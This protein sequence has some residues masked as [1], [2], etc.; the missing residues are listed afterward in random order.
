MHAETRSN[1]QDLFDVDRN[2]CSG[3]F[4]GGDSLDLPT[5]VKNSWEE[6]CKT[7]GKT[8]FAMSGACGQTAWASSVRMQTKTLWLSVTWVRVGF[9]FDFHGEKCPV[10]PGAHD[11][12]QHAFMPAG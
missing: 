7:P 12:R 6:Y 3:C 4:A 8:T 11:L 1:V 9:P 10:G 2:K 5:D